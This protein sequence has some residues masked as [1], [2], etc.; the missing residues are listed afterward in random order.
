MTTDIYMLSYILINGFRETAGSSTS[1]ITD[2]SSAETF[3]ELHSTFRSRR[4][5]KK[6]IVNEDLHRL[7]L[8]EKLTIIDE[9]ALCRRFFK[10]SVIQVTK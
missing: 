10:S 7:K 4:H 8:Q 9:L 2:S 5:I 3:Q 6:H 1:S